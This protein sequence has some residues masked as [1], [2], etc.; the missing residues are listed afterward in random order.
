MYENLEPIAVQ[1]RGRTATASRSPA[2]KKRRHCPVATVCRRSC[3]RLPGHSPTG[4]S[5]IGRGARDR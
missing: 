5:P 2:E 3:C 1:S 4:V